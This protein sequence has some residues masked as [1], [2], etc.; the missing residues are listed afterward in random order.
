MN[1]IMEPN[2]LL[3]LQ[4]VATLRDG[5]F[6]YSSHLVMLLFGG[7]GKDDYSPPHNRSKGLL[8]AYAH[9]YTSNVNYCCFNQRPLKYN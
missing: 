7:H 2:L 4:W 1:I 5:A 9:L 8:A 6:C 3:L